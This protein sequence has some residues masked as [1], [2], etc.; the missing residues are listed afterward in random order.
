MGAPLVVWDV[1]TKYDWTSLHMFSSTKSG[2]LR[3]I[4]SQTHQAWT[5]KV[6][7]DV[8]HFAKQ[9]IQ[10]FFG[11]QII[12]LPSWIRQIAQQCGKNMSGWWFEPL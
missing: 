3:N 9:K 2:T 11:Q 4:T 10:P 8:V 6:F 7:G 1:P 5:L 12:E